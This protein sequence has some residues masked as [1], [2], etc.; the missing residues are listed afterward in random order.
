MIE[1][2]LFYKHRRV[3][4]FIPVINYN[5]S[6]KRAFVLPF[7]RSFLFHNEPTTC[8]VCAVFTVY[9]IITHSVIRVILS[10]C[11]VSCRYSIVWVKVK[12][13]AF[14][15][16]N[17][18]VIVYTVFFFKLPVV[19][20]IINK[21]INCS[22]FTSLLFQGYNCPVCVIYKRELFY[23][24]SSRTATTISMKIIMILCGLNGYER[25]PA[26]TFNVTIH[27]SSIEVR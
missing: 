11:R 26:K 16:K 5:V 22:H 18:A 3:L 19:V 10:S 15:V 24:E 12:I 6:S 1:R 20:V 17:C 27:E 2:C 21:K 8:N 9:C 25:M 13:V 4:Y 23:A 7:K 14:L